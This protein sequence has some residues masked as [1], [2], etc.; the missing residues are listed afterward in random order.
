M[1]IPCEE[2]GVGRDCRRIEV[3]KCSRQRSLARYTS[4]GFIGGDRVVYAQCNFR[5]HLVETVVAFRTAPG[6]PALPDGDVEAF[7]ITGAEH[8]TF[9]LAL[10]WIHGFS[11][12]V[13]TSSCWVKRSS[14]Q[15]SDQRLGHVPFPPLILIQ[16]GAFQGRLCPRGG[17]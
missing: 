4:S 11:F 13:V 5:L 3:S 16:E 2:P 6:H 15:C 8:V 9:S 10:K 7:G 14:V 12:H 1:Q 17:L